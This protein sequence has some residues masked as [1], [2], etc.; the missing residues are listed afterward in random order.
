MLSSLNRTVTAQIK[1]NL[2]GGPQGPLRG[3]FP[4]LLGLALKPEAAQRL[5]RPPEA[6]QTLNSSNSYS[7]R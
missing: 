4:D 5:W 3:S 6:S 7:K 1:D 2:L